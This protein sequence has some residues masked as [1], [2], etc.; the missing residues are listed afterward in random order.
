MCGEKKK[1]R[2]AVWQGGRRAPERENETRAHHAPMA[3]FLVITLK[4][5]WLSVKKVRQFSEHGLITPAQRKWG[6]AAVI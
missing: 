6:V 5:E 1:I 2:Q 4:T 3:Y